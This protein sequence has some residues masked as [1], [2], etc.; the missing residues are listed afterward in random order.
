MISFGEF[1]QMKNKDIHG[2]DVRKSEY[3]SIRAMLE[4]IKE[5][6]RFVVDAEK[7]KVIES[8]VEKLMGKDDGNGIRGK[9]NKKK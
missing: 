7:R 6:I 4:A 2:S 1:I 5:N 8:F 9:D 3:A